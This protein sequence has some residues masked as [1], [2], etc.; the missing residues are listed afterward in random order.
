MVDEKCRVTHRKQLWENS[1]LDIVESIGGNTWKKKFMLVVIL[2]TLS[3]HQMNTFAL[4]GFKGERN[5]W[6]MVKSLLNAQHE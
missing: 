1:V 6:S 4:V 3:R 2:K 5:V